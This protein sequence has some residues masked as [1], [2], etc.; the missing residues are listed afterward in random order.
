M[1]P[2]SGAGAGW[3]VA[4]PAVFAAPTANAVCAF[5]AASNVASAATAIN[6]NFIVGVS[7]SLRPA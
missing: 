1:S 5:V 3:L 4:G 6:L 7:S 2:L